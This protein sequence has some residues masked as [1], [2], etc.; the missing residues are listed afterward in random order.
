[1]RWPKQLKAGGQSAALVSLVDCV[2]TFAALAGQKL[3][4]EDAP[5]S[6]D[7]S[8]A[9]L[10]PAAA[11]RP[12]FIGQDPQLS[13]REG[14]WKFIPANANKKG[15]KHPDTGLLGDPDAFVK[16]EHDNGSWNVAQLYDTAADPRETNNLAGK[17][18]ERVKAMAAA[19]EKA[20]ADGRTRAN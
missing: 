9:L 1:V 8:A 6:F 2:A 19:L 17:E 5:D 11:G 15:P 7:V 20:K 3:A 13:L 4:Q 18:P 12:S 14:K 16:G 10:D